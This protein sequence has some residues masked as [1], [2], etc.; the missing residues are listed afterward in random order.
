MFVEGDLQVLKAGQ[1]TGL[2]DLLVD[3]GLQTKMD[4]QIVGL[5]ALANG[6][7]HT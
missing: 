3:G 7:L 2:I 6:G 5:V 4:G 1:V